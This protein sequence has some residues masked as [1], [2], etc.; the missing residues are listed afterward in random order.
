MKQTHKKVPAEYQ[1]QMEYREAQKDL[2]D[3]ELKIALRSRGIDP[4]DL[5]QKD[6]D[7]IRRHINKLQQIDTLTKSKMKS[8]EQ[9][10]NKEQTAISQEIEVIIARLYQEQ[11]PMP[12]VPEMHMDAGQTEAGKQQPQEQTGQEGG[13]VIEP[14]KEPVDKEV[15]GDM[16][17]PAPE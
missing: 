12:P 5:P 9:E 10:G 6:L 4:Y 2:K 3:A 14:G 1:E 13:S 17:I 16:T 7:E 11:N 8:I 15:P